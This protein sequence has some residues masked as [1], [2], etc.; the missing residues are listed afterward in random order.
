MKVLKKI[1][2]GLIAILAIVVILLYATGYGYILRGVRVTYLNGH[3]TAFLDDYN[4]FDND[5]LYKSPTP[6]P[7]A[8]AID[9][10]KAKA[11][12]KLEKLHKEIQSVAFLVIKNDSIWYEWYNEGYGKDSRTNSF[13]MAKSIVS[14]AMGKAI[15]E[16]KLSGFDAKV[17]QFIPEFATGEAANLTVGDLSSMASGLEWD[18]KYY[19]PFSKTTQLYFD[20]NLAEFMKTIPVKRNPGREYEYSSGA[21]QLLAMT[22]EKATGE[23]LTKY[24]D[25]NFW[26]PIGAES[27]SYW[28][29]DREG[30]VKAYCCIASNARDFARFGKLYKQN[31]KWNGKQILDSAFVAKSL[32][33]RFELTPQYG[34]GW[35][36]A[37]FEQKKIFYMRGHLGQYVIVVPQD[38]LIIVRLGHQGNHNAV[39]QVHSSDFWTYLEEVYK[40]LAARK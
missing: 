13:S 40:M 4:Y 21:T 36:L 23:K 38:D 3:S 17:G 1:L 22:L 9:Y 19:S 35:W 20:T 25:D 16:G 2:I 30:L 7:W 31:G 11:S 39:N 26:K 5:T 32:T 37:E 24:V 14:A 12:S 10:N 18:E 28:Q 33:P 27:D 6:E 29:T 15:M 34:Y 8:V